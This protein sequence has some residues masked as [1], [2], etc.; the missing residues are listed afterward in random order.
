MAVKRFYSE[1]GY[2]VFVDENDQATRYAIAD[3]LTAAGIPALAASKITSGEFD[4]DRIPDLDAAKVATGTLG[5]D[6]IPS[7][8]AAKI[9]TGVLDSAR[10]PDLAASKVI[11][12]TFPTARVADA[13]ITPPKLSSPAVGAMGVYGL[14]S[15]GACVYG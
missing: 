4:A 15:Y 3:I 5:A 11:S 12:G 7:L 13:A 10:V 6:R 9:A 14:T 8:D 1:S 2:L